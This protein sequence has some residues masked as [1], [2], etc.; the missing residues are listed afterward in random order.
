MQQAQ[1]L[2]GQVVDPDQE[3]A[4]TLAGAPEH[5]PQTSTDRLLVRLARNRDLVLLAIAAAVFAVFS[6]TTTTFLREFNLF[7]ILRSISLISVVAVGMTYVLIAGEIDLSVGSVY[8]VL[9]V[10]MGMLVA[11]VGLSPWVAMPVVILIGIAIGAVNGLFIVG[12]G[13]PS[14]ITTLAMLA[15]YRS[16]ALI[17]SHEKP[18]TPRGGSTFYHLTGGELLGQVPWLILWMLPVAVVGGTVLARTR[19]GYHVYATGGNREAARDSGIAVQRVRW[20]VFMLTSALC[21]LAAALVFGYLQVAGPTTGVGFEFRVIGAVVVGGTALTGGRG[22]I[23]GTLLGAVVIGMI[24]GGMVLYG[25]SQNVGDI[26]TGL[27]IV[28][29]G[30]LDLALRRH[31]RNRFG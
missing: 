2:S 9:T 5:A 12:F 28:V 15:G 29:V 10:A 27:L 4:V 19:F 11:V 17:I 20:L 31:L 18:L 25:Y 8:G 13:I 26:A 23:A 1:Q 30:S 21:G 14:F 6:L 7:N 22:S 3:M 24:T 16:L